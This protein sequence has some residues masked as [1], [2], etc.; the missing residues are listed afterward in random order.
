[1]C[2]AGGVLDPWSLLTISLHLCRSTFVPLG[3]LPRYHPLSHQMQHSVRY[4]PPDPPRLPIVTR[5]MTPESCY[6]PYLTTRLFGPT[7]RNIHGRGRRPNPRLHCSH[8]LLSECSTE[9]RAQIALWGK[10]KLPL[11]Y[12]F[13]FYFQVFL[14]RKVPRYTERENPWTN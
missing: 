7:N 5:S 11:T 12:F 10:R 13:D 6:P 3:P 9:P 2:V 4:R 14:P 8:T 1:M